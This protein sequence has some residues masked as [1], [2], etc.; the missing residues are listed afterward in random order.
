MMLNKRK[1]VAELKELIPVVIEVQCAINRKL[2]EY[3]LE[4]QKLTMVDSQ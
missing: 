3:I 2:G 4:L 1:R